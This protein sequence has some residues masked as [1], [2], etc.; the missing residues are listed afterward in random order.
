MK[1]KSRPI[2][3]EAPKG[4][5]TKVKVGYR[6]ITIDWV[7]PDFKTDEL[8]DCFGQYKSREGLIQIQHNLCGQ[9][10]SNTI[11]HEICHAII[12]GSGLNQA[13]GPLKEE[14]SEELVVNQM[15]NYLMGVF[16]DNPWFLDYIKE[17]MDKA[18]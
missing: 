9:E 3:V 16:R 1:K 18:K 7:A 8:T 14:D 5:P 17:N 11:L 2:S 10:K 4:E 13:N 6:D 12:Y 15:T